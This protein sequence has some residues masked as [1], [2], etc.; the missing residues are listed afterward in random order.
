MP[1]TNFAPLG[2]WLSRKWRTRL[3]DTGGNFYTVATQL[4]KQGVPLEVALAL[5]CGRG[6]Q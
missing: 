6:L 4:R 5:L 3:A 2:Q 1:A